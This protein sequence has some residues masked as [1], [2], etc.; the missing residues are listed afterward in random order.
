MNFKYDLT[1]QTFNS[2][3]VRGN[4]QYRKK[5]I[6]WEA[7][8]MGC[9]VVKFVEAHAVKTGR[10]RSC[11]KCSA[12][13]Q[14]PKLTHGMSKSVEYR[15]YQAARTRCTNP[16][17]KQFKYWGGRGI[18]FR[19]T[20]FEQFYETLGPRPGA[21]YSIDRINND[22]HYEP[23]NVQWVTMDKQAKNKRPRNRR[24]DIR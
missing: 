18:E 8:C 17:Q 21:I 9:G 24:Y 16:K 23:G 2:W 7:V 6:Y 13:L 22:G 3:H 15:T 12:I 5:M 14:P 11:R 19:F 1:G 10:T 20:S 4:P